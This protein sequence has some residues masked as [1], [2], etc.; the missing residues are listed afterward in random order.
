MIKKYA[1]VIKIALA[2][3]LLI[4]VVAL[5]ITVSSLKKEKDRLAYNLEVE[6]SNSHDTQQ[7]ITYAELKEYFSKE[8]QT[9]KEHG[10]RPK[11]VENI[12]NVQYRLIDTLLYRDTLIYVY[13]TVKSLRKAN[14]DIRSQCWSVSGYVDS[15]DIYIDNFD[16][17]DSITVA[18]Y[19]ERRKCLFEKRKVKAI[20]ISQCKGDTLHVYRN[21]KINK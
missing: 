20:A 12:I 9:L 4:A 11:N 5:A 16:F 15:S 3:A 7:T 18:L 2:A 6:M 21:L 13:D 1:T 19:K 17:N 10:V 14:F 8:I